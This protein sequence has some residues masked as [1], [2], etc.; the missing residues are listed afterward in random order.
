[1]RKLILKLIVKS[2]GK[3]IQEEKELIELIK[4]FEVKQE[5]LKSLV[6]ERNRLAKANKRCKHIFCDVYSDSGNVLVGKKCID[7]NQYHSE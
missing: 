1:M 4:D 7:C 5:K 2:Y 3:R 6:A